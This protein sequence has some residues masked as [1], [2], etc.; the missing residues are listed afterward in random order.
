MKWQ[1]IET[2]PN[3]ERV[4]LC[5]GEPFFGTISK[6]I[7]CGYYDEESGKFLFWLSDREINTNKVTHWMP[8]PELPEE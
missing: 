8:L 5:Y 2:I 7:E 4:L 3:D 1:P 6:T